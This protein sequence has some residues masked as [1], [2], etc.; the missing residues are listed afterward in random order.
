MVSGIVP[1]VQAALIG[2]LLMGVLGCVDFASAYR[3]IDWKTIVL[4]V[5]MLPFSI[6]LERT[7]GVELA[8]EGLKTLTEGAGNSVV[9]ATLFA[10]TAILGMFISNTATAVLMAPVALAVSQGHG[11]FALSVRHDRGARGLDG[12]HDAGFVPGEYPGGGAGTL[13][14]RRFRPHRRSL[15]LRRPDRQRN[16]GAAAYSPSDA[17]PPGVARPLSDAPEK[18]P[19]R[20][21]KQ[22]RAFPLS[23]RSRK[24]E[25]RNAGRLDRQR[26]VDF[27]VREIEG[28]EQLFISRCAH[29]NEHVPRRIDKSDRAFDQ[30]RLPT[31]ERQHRA[32]AGK[33]EFG[34]ALLHVHRPPAM[35]IRNRQPRLAGR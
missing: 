13:H 30:R 29:E 14:V 5:G 31:P 11:R 32:I 4:I 9:L 35:R 7:G 18:N 16:P 25:R 10:I 12:L 22:V 24:V 17:R 34:S 27:L 8:A 1:N 21:Q 26:R 28:A 20:R 19:E 15:F 23:R 6:A 2:C 33:T 3:S